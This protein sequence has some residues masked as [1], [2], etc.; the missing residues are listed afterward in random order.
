MSNIAFVSVS[1][2]KNQNRLIVDQMLY[3]RN[4]LDWLISEG[5]TVLSIHLETRNPLIQIQSCKHCDQ[6][7]GATKIRRNGS[8]GR[9]ITMATSVC[10]CQV[11]W[12]VH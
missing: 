1:T 11:E 3:V 12:V 6:L 9:E 4:A 2:R 10:F 7:Q 5:Y 8:T